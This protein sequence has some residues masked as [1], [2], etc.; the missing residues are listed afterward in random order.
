MRERYSAEAETDTE[1][2]VVGLSPPL[3][4]LLNSLARSLL[5][6]TR[7]L[8]TGFEGDLLPLLLRLLLVLLLLLL[9]LLLM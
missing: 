1:A 6:L 3:S 7:R 5:V 9:L 4:V 8:A 2:E